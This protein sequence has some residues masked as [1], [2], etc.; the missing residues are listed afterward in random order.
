MFHQLGYEPNSA[1]DH[2]AEL[3]IGPAQSSCSTFPFYSLTC[4]TLTKV[5]LVILCVALIVHFV[6]MIHS[7]KAGK[8]TCHGQKLLLAVQSQFITPGWAKPLTFNAFCFPHSF[9]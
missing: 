9:Y 1:H 2:Q 6:F 5:A 8:L 3:F 7:N 4:A